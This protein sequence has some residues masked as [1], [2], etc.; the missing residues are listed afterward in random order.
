M[1]EESRKKKE[2]EE[3]RRNVKLHNRNQYVLTSPPP[4]KYVKTDKAPLRKIQNDKS[5]Q[6]HTTKSSSVIAIALE[7][8]TFFIR[9]AGR[10]NHFTH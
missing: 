5:K 2:K 4:I 8:Y 7:S 3:E 1:S 9:L 10:Q 6:I